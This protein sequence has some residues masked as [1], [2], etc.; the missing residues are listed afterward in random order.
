MRKKYLFIIFILILLVGLYFRFYNTPGRWSLGGDSGRDAIV[1]REGAQQFQLPLTG[2]FSSLGPFT[3]GPWYYYILIFF[4]RIFP[5]IWAPWITNG[6]L[7]LFTIFGMFIIGNL[8]IGPMFGLL[9]AALT[10]F[11]PAQISASTSL[12]QPSFVSPFGVLSL[13]L[14]MQIFKKSVPL[15]WGILLGFSLGLMI[16]MHY[17]AVLFLLLPLCLL[18]YKDKRKFLPLVFLGLFLSF[19]PLLFFEFTNHWFN[20]RGLVQ[21]FLYDQY[22]LWTSTRWLTYLGNFWPSFWSYVTGIHPIFSILI[23]GIFLIIFI[24]SILKK[25]LAT[26]WIIFFIHFLIMVFYLR[27]WRGEK[28]FGYLQFFHP[29]IFLFTGYVLYQII[30]R[31]KAIG[32]V[33]LGVYFLIALINIKP[34]LVTDWAHPDAKRRV[35]LLYQKYPGDKFSIYYCQQDREPAQAMTL[36]LD[37]DNRYSEEGRKIGVGLKCSLP[38]NVALLPYAKFGDLVDINEATP[39]A[40]TE[41]NWYLLSPLGIFNDVTRWWFKL[42]P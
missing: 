19:L 1:A 5:F 22:R 2:S 15:W 24:Q 20:T 39:T 35:N 36:L 14:F 38:K 23:I 37:M 10:A 42:Q 11:S 17:Q 31:S 34:L 4:Q 8:L 3:F 33:L 6:F 27:Y 28:S 12:L 26:P 13:I 21:F 9:V 41:T 16:N 25:H 18:F 32:A 40:I 29:Y 7:S 30:K